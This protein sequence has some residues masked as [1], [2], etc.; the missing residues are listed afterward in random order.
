MGLTDTGLMRVITQKMG[1][2]SQRLSVLSQNVANADTPGFKA[3][4]LEPFTFE[5]AMRAASAGM[6]ITNPNHILPASMAG[7]ASRTKKASS[8]ETV[9]SGNSVD[10]EQQMM[11]VSQTSIDYQTETSLYHKFLGFFRTAV[12]K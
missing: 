3:K 9:P 11:Q 7:G 8:Y 12:G 2:D 4:D 10:L 1:Y 6:A 5:S